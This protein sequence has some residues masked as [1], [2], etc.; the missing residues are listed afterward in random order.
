MPIVDE[1]VSPDDYHAQSPLLFWTI[2]A[3]ASRND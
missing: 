3:I 1:K 2:I